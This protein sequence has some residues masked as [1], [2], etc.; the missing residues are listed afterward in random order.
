[1]RVA[2]DPQGPVYD[3]DLP[4]ELEEALA[5]CPFCGGPGKIR[6]NARAGRQAHGQRQTDALPDT[7]YI[8][9]SKCDAQGPACRN[10]I[11]GWGQD[12]REVHLNSVIDFKPVAESMREAVLG[13]NKRPPMGVLNV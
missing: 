4:P 9:C 1:M 6:D 7:W 3:C 2:D 11:D 8:Q 13:W 10:E 12:G 5:P